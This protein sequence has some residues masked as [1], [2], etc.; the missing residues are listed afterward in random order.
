MSQKY[1]DP[2]PDERINPWVP[3]L[4]EVKFRSAN[5][6]GLVDFDFSRPLE[7]TQRHDRWSPELS[8][9]LTRSRLVSWRPSF[10]L[11]YSWSREPEEQARKF[12]S[13]SGRDRLVTF[14]FPDDADVSKIAKELRSLPEVT[15]ANPV[16]K[17]A[18]PAPISEPLLGTSDQDE[19]HQW[20]AFRCKLPEALE[21]ATGDGVIVAVI[22]WGLDDSHKEYGPNI[23]LRKNMYNNDSFVSDGNRKH[24]TASM[25]LAGARLNNCGI[26][27]FAPDSILWAIQAGRDGIVNH[28]CWAAGIDFVR[29]EPASQRKVIILEI[30]TVT[31]RNVES[32]ELINQAIRDAIAANIVVCV[33]A[34]N[35]PLS[36]PNKDDDQEDIP[37]TCSVLVGATNFDPQY[38][39]VNSSMGPRVV[40]YA[41]GARQNDLTCQPSGGHTLVFG[42]TSG[43]VAKVGG[44]VALMLEANPSLT[45]TQVRDILGSSTIPALR[46]FDDPVGVLLDCEDAVYRATHPITEYRECVPES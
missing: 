43:A 4:V 40:V 19:E 9:I 12:Y 34:G 7:R 29:S 41:P 26:V 35:D 23:E 1:S 39:F 3:G 37:V 36:D 32:I 5:D 14:R 44:A 31:K 30:Q 18:P 25:G 2:E 8:Q 22:D 21:T 13:T 15:R 42:G 28:R 27:G 20:Y 6:S 45:P 24:G 46:D 11:R 16:A 38:N 17:V 33:P 10:P